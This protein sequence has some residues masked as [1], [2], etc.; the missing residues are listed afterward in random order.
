MVANNFGNVCGSQSGPISDD[1]L[2][3]VIGNFE[4][5]LRD[6]PP[7]SSIRPIIL[8]SQGDAFLRRHKEQ[9]YS[10]DLEDAITSY[11]KALNLNE[12]IMPDESLPYATSQEHPG[13]GEFLIKLATALVLRFTE[14]G[15]S[16]LDDYDRAVHLFEE[17]TELTSSPPT[18]RIIA[19]QRVAEFLWSTDISR[20]SKV[21]KTAVELLPS[22]CPYHLTRIDQQHSLSLFSG[23]AR[24]A[25]AMALEAQMPPSE[26]AVLLDAGRNIIMARRLDIRDDVEGLPEE[27]SKRYRELQTLLDPPLNIQQQS[28]SGFDK[29][30]STD[31]RHA[32]GLEM[33]ELKIK[34]RN[35]PGFDQFALP[36]TSESLMQQAK[37]G[38]IIIVNVSQWCSDALIITTSEIIHEPLDSLDSPTLITK[39]EAFRN[40]L[41]MIQ[42]ISG[43]APCTY[44]D[45]V[46][47]T[48]SRASQSV[49]Q[50][51]C[52]RKG[53]FSTF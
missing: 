45:I 52:N 18:T 12:F 3:R 50:K 43:C 46:K 16:S 19:A 25:A 20:A 7:D 41:R 44:T 23:L 37:Y 26:T 6:L 8:S 31:L 5:V 34:I 14:S 21:L 9:R 29:Y 53:R 2:D 27:L 51:L 36:L 35:H 17:A 11:R 22:T 48:K 47:R 42:I 49:H 13:R 15:F 4:S 33:E 10:T 32:A 24:D 28:F 39:V 30:R 40:C 1:L 38:E